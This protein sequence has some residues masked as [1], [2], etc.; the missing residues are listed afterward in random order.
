VRRR[1]GR[2]RLPDAR[3]DPCVLLTDSLAADGEP[4]PGPNR[5]AHDNTAVPLELLRKH[6]NAAP[7]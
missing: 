2:G 5:G 6:G 3:T 1:V 4:R 7:H